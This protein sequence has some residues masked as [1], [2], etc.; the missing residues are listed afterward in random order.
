MQAD[1]IGTNSYKIED[2]E[3]KSTY[4]I[5]VQAIASKYRNSEWS[6]PVRLCIS[7]YVDGLSDNLSESVELVRVYD[8]NGIMVTE[9]KANEINRLRVRRGIYIIMYRNGKTRKTLISA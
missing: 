1:S 7:D 9:C 6:S 4:N 5:C 2:L 8:M 3:E